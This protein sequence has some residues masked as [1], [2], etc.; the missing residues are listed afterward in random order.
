MRISGSQGLASGPVSAQGP[1]PSLPVSTSP[2][3]PHRQSTAS[4]TTHRQQFRCE[5]HI[6]EPAA[7]KVTGNDPH[8]MHS[9]LHLNTTANTALAPCRMPGSR[10]T[11]PHT[12][13][14]M[15]QRHQCPH[16][17]LHTQAQ[18][19]L[20]LSPTP[21]PYV[22]AIRPN[23]VPEPSASVPC[24]SFRGSDC[25]AHARRATFV[26]S[27]LSLAPRGNVC[28]AR[29]LSIN[30]PDFSPRFTL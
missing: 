26:L 20:Y 23:P 5:Q 4:C 29:Y 19:A 1:Q 28:P 15:L 16:L 10:G 11:H 25:S 24:V 8:N 12:W 21:R 27:I 13:C 6:L 3:D 22:S 2:A 9:L 17:R 18:A 14:S 7:P 30:Y